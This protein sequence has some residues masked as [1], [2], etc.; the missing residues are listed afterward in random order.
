[1]VLDAKRKKNTRIDIGNMKLT[2]QAKIKRDEAPRKYG[3]FADFQG[4]A[5]DWDGI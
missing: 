1:M 3:P 5:I 4:N 2:S